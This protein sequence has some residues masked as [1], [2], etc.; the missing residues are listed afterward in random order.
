MRTHLYKPRWIAKAA[1]VGIMAMISTNAFAELLGYRYTDIYGEQREVNRDQQY[2]NPSS[3]ISFFLRAGV[4]RRL[5]I[6]LQDDRGRTVERNISPLLGANDRITF[7]GR[8]HYG[9]ML[10]LSVPTD[11]VYNAVSRILDSS[12][13]VI[14][15]Y[16]NPL[17]IDRNA[18]DI[19]GEFMPIVRS[20]Q[21]FYDGDRLYFGLGP[22][23]GIAVN[24]GFEIEGL[25]D[26][27]G[28]KQYRFSAIQNSNGAR[29]QTEWYSASEKA[30]LPRDQFSSLMP[31]NR[32]NYDLTLELEDLAGNRSTLTQKVNYAFQLDYEPIPVAVY[33]GKP[34]DT[35]RGMSRYRAY[36]EGVALETPFTEFVMAVRKNEY[37]DNN[38][39]GLMKGTH[40]GNS[41]DT[42]GDGGQLTQLDDN[43]FLYF[44]TD[45]RPITRYGHNLRGHTYGDQFGNNSSITLSYQ[46]VEG[47]DLAPEIT[48]L[49]MYYANGSSIPSYLGVDDSWEVGYVDVEIEPRNFP[50]RLN[51]SGAGNTFLNPGE[52]QKRIQVNRAMTSSSA[53][54]VGQYLNIY[55]DIGDGEEVQGQAWSR[56]FYVS[57]HEPVLVASRLDEENL[58]LEID[59]STPAA[60]TGYFY[61]YYGLLSGELATVSGE[62]LEPIRMDRHSPNLHT[63]YFNLNDF[64]EGAHNLKNIKFWER[65]NEVTEPY[66]YSWVSDFNIFSGRCFYSGQ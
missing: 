9:S 1:L 59:V 63:L 60:G 3:E 62:T 56:V 47:S 65:Y 42:I 24:S 31:S 61:D 30:M 54:R 21:Y 50:I 23:G 49:A 36:T 32:R 44:K 53:V 34:S 8:D 16:S 66:S 4:D 64:E 40:G 45:R 20:A 17:V 51:F 57:K 2:V 27:V 5:E 46:S 10:T 35:W 52:T 26:N 11:G 58:L 7:G 39:H 37:V 19:G 14:E 33:T 41:Y 43:E 18:P 25:S 15:Q 48:S 55:M 29:R 38:I 12:G 13:T 6:D 28:L 22:S